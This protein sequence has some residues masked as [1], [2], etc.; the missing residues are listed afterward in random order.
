M[1]QHSHS[2][3]RDESDNR[4][5][6]GKLFF[7]AVP[8]KALHEK[9]RRALLGVDGI[10]EIHHQ[11]LWSLDGEHH[12]LTAHV[13]VDHDDDLNSGE[14][15][16]IKQSITR[17]LEQYQLAHTTI[18]IELKQESCRDQAEYHASLPPD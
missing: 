15:C 2:H 11:H 13:V 14:Y 18:E 9:I 17:A 1:H 6:T 4:M 16:A 8:D 3:H 5:V 7:Q 10:S 12:V